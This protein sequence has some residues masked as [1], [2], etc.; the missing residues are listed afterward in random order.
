M[1]TLPCKCTKKL[2]MHLRTR[3]SNFPYYLPILFHVWYS[4]FD[5]GFDGLT[6]W[7]LYMLTQFYYIIPIHSTLPHFPDQKLDS[8]SHSLHYP[9]PPQQ[10]PLFPIDPSPNV[11]RICID[12]TVLLSK[13]NQSLPRRWPGV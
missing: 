11:T 1:R 3:I 2:H 7:A 12:K 9:H 4:I 5:R 6:L 13:P 10:N 8:E